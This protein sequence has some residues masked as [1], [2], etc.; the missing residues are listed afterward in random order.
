MRTYPEG[1][2]RIVLME[3]MEGSASG[4]DGDEAEPWGEDVGIGVC[5]DVNRAGGVAALIFG[6]S[7]EVNAVDDA[8]DTVLWRSSIEELNEGRLLGEIFE[9]TEKC[10]V[11]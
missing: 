6:C 3:E 8:V 10:C 4:R 2:G 1:K 11:K 9:E 5:G 7:S